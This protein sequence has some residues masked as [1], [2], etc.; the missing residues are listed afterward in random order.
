MNINH[1]SIYC[2]ESTYMILTGVGDGVIYVCDPDGIHMENMSAFDD[3]YYSDG[4]GKYCYYGLDLVNAIGERTK[5][6]VMY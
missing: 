2:D 3:N 1:P 4:Y 5:M 6:Y